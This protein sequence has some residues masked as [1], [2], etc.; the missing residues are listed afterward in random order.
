MKEVNDFLE[1]EWFVVRHSGE[2]PEV[3]Y[4]SAIFFLTRD[5]EGPRLALQENEHM[6]LKEAAAERY[7]EIVLRDLQAE[8]R[9]TP[10]YRG[11]QRS[12]HNYRRFKQFCAREEFDM[13]RFAEKVSLSLQ[14]ILK[15]EAQERAE[16]L[17]SSA[18]NCTFDEL[19]GFADE[20][21]L[22]QGILSE[23]LANLCSESS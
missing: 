2:M 1:D 9:G 16:G 14:S 13:G 19:S 4:H 17:Q 10:A 18:L 20:L 15:V 7:R 6:F 8:N 21:G 11:I 3:A 5:E 22:D 23:E 12:I